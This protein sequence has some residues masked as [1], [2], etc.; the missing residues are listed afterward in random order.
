M[1]EKDPI[2]HAEDLLK[3]AHNSAHKYARPV[4]RRYPLLFAFTITFS[5]A[6]VLHGF[7]LW[8]DQIEFFHTHPAALMWIGIVALFLTGT[9]YKALGNHK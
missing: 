9:L 1:L 4:L 5:V 8:A 6:A 2:R 3:K 7:E